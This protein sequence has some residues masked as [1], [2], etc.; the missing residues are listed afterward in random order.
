MMRYIFRE[1]N[2]QKK[3]GRKPEIVLGEDTRLYKQG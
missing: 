1:W 2:L 3:L